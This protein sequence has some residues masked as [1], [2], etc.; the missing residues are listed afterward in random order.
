[1]KTC[2]FC[3]IAQHQLTADL[4]Y[5]DQNILA[6]KDIAPK[7]P[8]HFLIIPKKH[9]AT[10]NEVQDFHTIAQMTETAVQLAKQQQIAA[11]GYRLLMNCN[12]QA[13]QEV[14]HIHL[15]LLGGK[16]LGSIG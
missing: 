11:S 13:G 3:N 12:Q 10:L 5:E 15:H 8:V 2:I 14:F 4:L 7:A 6:F 16:K 1:M 9:I